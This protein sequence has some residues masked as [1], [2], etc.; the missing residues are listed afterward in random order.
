M[1]GPRIFY[2]IVCNLF[3][4]PIILSGCGKENN[5][6][7]LGIDGCVYVAEQVSLP[8]EAGNFKIRNGY[9]YWL[10]H[11]ENGFDIRKVPV[12]EC[13]GKR[14]VLMLSAGESVLPAGSVPV[15]STVYEVDEEGNLFYLSKGNL[16]VRQQPDGVAEYMVQIGGSGEGIVSLAEGKTGKLAAATQEFIYVINAEGEV[17]DKVS[18]GEYTGRENLPD[19]MYVS[20]ELLKGDSGRIYCV[21]GRSLWELVDEGG[22]CLK[23]LKDS[24]GQGELLASSQGL[25]YNG[26]DG[27]LYRCREDT[28]VCEAL[29]RWNDSMTGNRPDGEILWISEEKLAV[30]Y[31]G[32]SLEAGL[33]L[34]TK[35]PT[36]EL[37]EKEV[38]V[39]AVSS[40]SDSLVQY[41]LKFNRNN[42]RYHVAMEYYQGEAAG[43]RLDARIVSSNPPDLIDLTGMEVEKYAGKDVLENLNPYLEQ[44]TVLGPEDFLENMLES[45]I[46]NGSLVCL[47]REFYCDTVIGRASQVGSMPGWTM[48]DVRILTEEYPQKELFYNAGI[49][50]LVGKFFGSY[51]LESYIDWKSGEC[52]FDGEKFIAFMEWIAELTGGEDSEDVFFES[53]TGTMDKGRLLSVSAMVGTLEDILRE[54]IF[55]QEKVTAT[56]YPSADGTARH[57]SHPYNLI[58]IV[59]DSGR[60]EG[61]WQFLEAFLT[62]SSIDYLFLPSRKSVLQEKA[63]YLMEP[64]Y[65]LDVNGETLLKKD[66]TPLIIPKITFLG[67]ADGSVDVDYM[68]V[69]QMEQVYE[70]IATADFTLRDSIRT[71]ILDIIV[72]EMSPCLTGNKTYEQAA[73][74]VQNRVQNMV[75]ESISDSGGQG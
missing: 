32:S 15:M 42:E 66:G 69:E 48:E 40:P 61:A 29:L 36:E 33:Y 63:E 18:T 62:D 37:P 25:M 75:R 13:F 8:E 72:E 9:L 49:S 70:V 53:M 59:A 19:G 10:M 73:A 2:Y 64:D 5:S 21:T 22:Y 4:I 67:I 74:V 44:S 56:G 60:K 3:F 16:L 6:Y 54:E 71:D 41:V 31:R 30:Y 35:T 34:L 27:I 46:V 50:A 28:G 26:S 17:E 43:T 45:Y 11:Q 65:R 23:K 24:N 52:S 55:F 51:I 39:L 14:D 47:P 20:I 12:E 7:N 1:N 38:L 68:T 58:G 57:Y